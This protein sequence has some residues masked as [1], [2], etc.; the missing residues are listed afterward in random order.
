MIVI[1]EQD[2]DM[3]GIIDIIEDNNFNEYISYYRNR[4]LKNPM[5]LEVLEEIE[6]SYG[7]YSFRVKYDLPNNPTELMGFNY[8]KFESLNNFKNKDE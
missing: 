3:V 7:A 1:W 6:D 4:L 5:Y 2:Y 8:S